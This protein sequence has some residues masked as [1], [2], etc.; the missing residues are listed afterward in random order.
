MNLI[1]KP[2]I[3]CVD[4]WENVLMEL[5]NL[6]KN[7]IV[8]CESKESEEFYIGKIINVDKKSLSLLYFNGAGE[9]DEKPIEILLKDITSI[10]FDSKYINLMSKYLKSHI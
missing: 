8:E 4:N 9:W 5:Y 7:I 2:S 6:G 1:G 3:N 10:N